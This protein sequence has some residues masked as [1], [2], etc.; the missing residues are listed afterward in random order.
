MY[1]LYSSDHH[2]SCNQFDNNIN[3]NVNIIPNPVYNMINIYNEITKMLTKYFKGFV[4]HTE[5][6]SQFDIN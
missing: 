2:Q 4:K 5:K 3:F 1:A 6:W